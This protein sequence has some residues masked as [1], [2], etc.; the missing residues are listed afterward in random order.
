MAVDKTFVI[1]GDQG[2]NEVVQMISGTV[3][4]TL[5]SLILKRQFQNKV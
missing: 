4:K 3:P 5:W 1:C 2:I